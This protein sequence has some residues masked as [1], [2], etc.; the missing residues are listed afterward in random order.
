MSVDTGTLVWAKMSGFPW[1]PAVTFKRWEDVDE[2]RIRCHPPLAPRLTSQRLTPHLLS[3]N[4]HPR[5]ELSAG[6]KTVVYFLNS[7]DFNALESSSLLPFKE[8]LETKRNSSKMKWHRESSLS[9]D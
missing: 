9:G 4:I 3:V 2:W 6:K 1:W 7:M 5:P 8:H